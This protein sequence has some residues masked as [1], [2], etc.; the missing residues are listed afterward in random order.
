VQSSFRGSGTVGKDPSVWG[1][2]SIAGIY[3]MTALEKQAKG[4]LREPALRKEDGPRI[5]TDGKP[6]IS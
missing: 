1:N 6:R 4:L 3:L 5:H 2:H